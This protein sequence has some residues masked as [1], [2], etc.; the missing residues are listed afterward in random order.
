MFL[1]RDG[2]KEAKFN[3]FCEMMCD[4]SVWFYYMQQRQHPNLIPLVDITFC[5]F[6]EQSNVNN[7]LRFPWLETKD[8]ERMK[9][10]RF[11]SLTS[12]IYK[13][14]GWIYLCRGIMEW[15]CLVRGIHRWRDKG[16]HSRFLFLW[17]WDE[18][19]P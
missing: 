13:G 1:A 11:M 3:L 19:C 15:G 4:S 16:G 8:L 5:E 7:V 9:V 18:I 12:P 2:R 10:C 6:I 17:T 14:L